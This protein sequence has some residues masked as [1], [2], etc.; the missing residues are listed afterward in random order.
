MRNNSKNQTTKLSIKATGWQEINW[1]EVNI[2]V[3][4]LQ[5]KIV[6]ATMK[7]NM[8]EV[9][10]LQEKLITSFEGKALAIRR[11]V[12]SQGG[13]TPGVDNV[14]WL[15]P[16][17]R[18]KAIKELGLITKDYNSYESSPLKRVMIPKS[19]STELRPLGIPTIMDRAVQAVYHLAIDPVVEVRSDPNSYGFR[20]GRSQH[21]AIAYIRSWMDKTHSPEYILVT[22][23]AKCMDKISHDFLLANTP[24]CHKHVLKEWLKSGFIFE[25]HKFSTDAGTPQGGVI[26]PTLCNIALNGVEAAI[27]EVY[28]LNKNVKGGRPK[29]YVCRFADDMVI[30]GINE[31]ILHHV[32]E[33]VQ[34]FLAIRGLELKEAKTKIV[35]IQKGFDFLGFNI[36]RKPFNPRLNNHTKQPTVLIIKPSDKSIKSLISKIKMIIGSNKP[37]IGILVKELNPV[38]RGWAN[39]FK[40]S[41]HSQATFIK[42]GHYLWTSMINWVSRKH[43]ETSIIKAVKQYIVQGNTRSRHKWV[44]GVNKADKVKENHEVILNIA[45][46]KPVVHPLLKLSRN[47]YLLEDKIYFDKRIIEK[48][49]A[50]FR[51][52]IYKKYNHLCPVCQESLHNGENVELHHIIPVKEGGKYTMSNIQPLH[53]ICHQNITH[54]AANKIKNKIIK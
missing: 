39:Y 24:I 16:A 43:P 18:F 45:E 9:Y 12:T 48:S 38:L 3:Q 25:G 42:I 20:K 6:K 51:E 13:K 2:R 44:W 19:N 11:V 46:V 10:R 34:E 32:K 1:K 5:D 15:T 27:H 41:Y 29:I 50:K 52:A 21:D 53:Q 49:S 17:D 8:N 7:N 54:G 14:T 35:T 37:E 30:T 22:D 40:I 31:E 4:D 23:I 36:S 28:P 33:I 47:P 26:S